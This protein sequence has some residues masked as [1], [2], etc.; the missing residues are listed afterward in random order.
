M[1]RL[2]GFKVYS[3]NDGG[4]IFISVTNYGVTF[5]KTSVEKLNYPEYVHVLFDD[6][7]NMAISPCAQDNEARVFVRNRDNVRAGFV[8]WNDKKLINYMI[9]L[10]GLKIGSKGIR[11]GGEYFP[12]E[13]IVIY[14]LKDYA[15]INQKE[16]EN[17]IQCVDRA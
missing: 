9:K 4:K 7:G 15:Q 8:R 11:M 3:R 12:D 10:G 1:S 17:E 6:N 14:N 5:S 16:E 2:D 13:N